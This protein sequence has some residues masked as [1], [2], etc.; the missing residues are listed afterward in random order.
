L[1]EGVKGI[2]KAKKQQMSGPRGVHLVLLHSGPKAVS[3]VQVLTRRYFK[4]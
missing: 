2:Y 1:G 3:Y 4:K